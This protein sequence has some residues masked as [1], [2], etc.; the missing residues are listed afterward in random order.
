MKAST[1]FFFLI[2]LLFFAPASSTGADD[3]AGTVFLGVS[4]GSY[5]SKNRAVILAMRDAAR[6]VSF[7][8][9]VE[10]RIK[11]SET[12]DPQLRI[13][14]VIEEKEL[15]HDAD[16]E[17]YIRL[18]EFDAE[19]D[20][21]EENGALF[22]RARYT[23]AIRGITGYRPGASHSGVRPPWVESPPAEIDEQPCAVGFGGPRLSY[24]DAVI[25]SYE[26]AVYALVKNS[27]YTENASQVAFERTAVDISSTH[28]SGIVK[29][30]RVLETW[31]DPKSGAVWT[32]AIAREV[33]HQGEE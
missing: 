5:L 8:H 13:S 12:Y 32:L 24:K 26:D 31:T 28:V 30:F 22:I 9:S 18:L 23:G 16:Y 4:S 21:Y 27:F 11:S 3:E 33:N 20:I 6:R 19:K 10:V 2:I 29:G 25:A 17:K 15:I 1:V 7:F 14:R